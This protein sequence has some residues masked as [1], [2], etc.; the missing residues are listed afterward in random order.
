[1]LLLRWCTMADSCPVES[2]IHALD[3]LFT[4]WTHCSRTGHILRGQNVSPCRRLNLLA[5]GARVWISSCCSFLPA[6]VSSPFSAVSNSS[7]ELA[8]AQYILTAG[9]AHRQ[10]ICL[11]G[12]LSIMLQCTRIV[13]I[14]LHG[15]LSAASEAC[16]QFQ[17][18]PSFC[19]QGWLS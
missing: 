8:L 18:S 9:K 1:M 14:S 19:G 16:L 3:T 12:K 5:S 13:L 17:P 6:S 4:H 11:A 7:C 10:L 2:A 15:M